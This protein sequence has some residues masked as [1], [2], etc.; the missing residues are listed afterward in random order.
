[1][2][3]ISAHADHREEAGPVTCQTYTEMLA[4]GAEY[5]EFDIRRT[6]DGV[7][8]AYHDARAGRGGPLVSGLGYP[9]L[10]DRL[11]Y[12]VPRVDEVMAVLAGRMTGHLDLKE[13]GYEAEVTRLASS[14]LG[15][16]NYVITSLEDVSVAAIK[17]ASPQTRTALSLGRSLKGVPRHRWAAVRH[18]EL[19]PMPR[20]RAC[21]ADAVAVNYRL[22]RLGV[23]RACHRHGVG[24]M[25]WTVDASPLIDQ[26]LA[27][28]RIDVLITN[29]PRHAARRRAELGAGLAARRGAPER[30]DLTAGRPEVA[31]TAGPPSR[32]ARRG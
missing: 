22:A 3:Q 13:A 9:A 28:P 8:V 20:V 19:F 21:G 16:A 11:G 4:S 25:V 23:T 7:L 18:S 2:V 1:V 6:A 15:A 14:I 17:R 12:A 10:C 24:V 5:A 27:D 32:P 29:R 31:G 30:Q 26:F